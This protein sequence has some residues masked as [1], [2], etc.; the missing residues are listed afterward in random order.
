MKKRKIFSAL[1]SAVMATS[2]LFTVAIAIANEQGTDLLQIQTTVTATQ[3]GAARFVSQD[4]IDGA[5]AASLVENFSLF[6]P[7]TL[8]IIINQEIIWIEGI[9]MLFVT[10]KD[11]GGGI[12]DVGYFL[13]EDQGRFLIRESSSTESR[14]SEPLSE[15]FLADMINI[16]DERILRFGNSIHPDEIIFV[17]EETTDFGNINEVYD[18][19]E[20]T[21]FNAYRRHFGEA[22]ATG[23]NSRG[24]LQSW[25]Y[26]NFD[27]HLVSI[28]GM[29]ANLSTRNG[30]IRGISLFDNNTEHIA[31]Q[32]DITR[33][34]TTF[35]F[36]FPWSVGAT[37]SG[38]T[39]TWSSGN[40][41]NSAIVTRDRPAFSGS[42]VGTL[43][44]RELLTIRSMADVAV[45]NGNSVS[46]HSASYTLTFASW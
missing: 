31:L 39:Q 23:S 7:H 13:Q 33:F 4:I 28:I 3:D 12:T 22:V 8:G 41:R 15:S 10:Y 30:A 6:A 25:I 44:R 46:I 45:R 11:M 21:I 37:I 20:I 42:W 14:S 40:V 17:E 18:D 24:I 5:V 38:D 35:S 26:H 43:L 27:G 2:I 34:G 16:S 32:E 19:F 1:I 9:P 36:A 29:H